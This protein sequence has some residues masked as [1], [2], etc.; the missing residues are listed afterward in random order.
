MKIMSFVKHRTKT[1][2][3]SERNEVVA[4]DEELA[5]QDTYL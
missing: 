4:T 1:E 5:V 3:I 2:T